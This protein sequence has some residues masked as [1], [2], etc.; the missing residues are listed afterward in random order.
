M[1]Y[2]YPEHTDRWSRR[3]DKRLDVQEWGRGVPAVLVHGS[4]TTGEENWEGQRPLASAGYR[5]VVPNRR[6]YGDSPNAGGEDF[7]RDGEDIAGLLGDP[8]HLVGHSYGGLV[9]LVAAHRRPEGVLSLTLI[10]P[11]VFGLCSEHPAV[12]SLVVEA[13]DLWAQVELTDRQFLEAF[14]R[15]VG[16]S[17]DDVPEEMLDAWT[18]RIPLVRRSRT[19]WEAQIPLD[20]AASSPVPTL[21]ISGDHHPAFNAV[22]EELTR[23]LDARSI[24]IPGAGHEV[25]MM[26][27]PCNR[28]L[29]EHWRSA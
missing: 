10:E 7:L 15:L 26:T 5:L 14:L 1:V 12:A 27:E 19:P 2:A 6:G 11:P 17:P 13:R 18:H 22:C 25:Q 28:A 4:L 16:E 20:R 23:R 21:V 8:A 3:Q 29:L 9:A 24:A